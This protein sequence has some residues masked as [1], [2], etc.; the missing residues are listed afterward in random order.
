MAGIMHL[1]K[2]GMGLDTWCGVRR[3]TLEG[4]RENTTCNSAEVSCQ[5]C[6]QLVAKWRKEY[7]ERHGIYSAEDKIAWAKEAIDFV[8]DKSSDYYKDSS[9]SGKD[10]MR[11]AECHLFVPHHESG[12]RV[13]AAKVLF[14]RGKK[15]G[16]WEEQ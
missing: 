5:K 2:T 4:E 15:M 3:N 7:N 8:L 16:L 6:L 1:R 11:C 12:C 14:E 13:Q 9:P 10:R